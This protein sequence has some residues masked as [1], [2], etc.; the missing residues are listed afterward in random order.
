MG[1]SFVRTLVVVVA[2]CALAACGTI[3]AEQTGA[4]VTAAAPAP[5]SAHPLDAAMLGKYCFTCHNSK[6]R[7]GGL[8]LDTKDLSHVSGDAEVWEKVLRKLR[9]GAMPPLGMPRPDSQTTVAFVQALEAQLDREA[10]L[11]PRPG[12]T[13]ALHR[14]NRAEYKNAIRDLLAL[15]IDTTTLLPPDAAD[16]QGL[17]NN[18]SLLTVSPALL[19]RYQILGQRVS[20]LAL[21]MPPSGPDIETFKMSKLSTQDGQGEGLPFGSRGGGAIRYNF[22]AD[23]KYVVKL[24]LKRQLYDYIIGLNEPE[25]IDLRIDGESV[26]TFKVGGEDHGLTAP[27]S[28]GGEIFGDPDWEHWVIHA[29][30]NFEVRLDVKAGPHVVDVSFAGRHGLA[31]DP[32]LRAKRTGGNLTRDETLPQAI[33][34]VVISGPYGAT[35]GGADTPSLRKIMLCRPATGAD[36]TPCAK[37]IISALAR[38]AYRRPVADKE[39]EGL[40]AF[41]REGRR[42]GD[43][44]AGLQ[45]ALARILTAPSFLFRVEP[46][47]PNLAPGATYRI[48]DLALASRLSFFLWSSIPDATL[49][50]LAVKG[51]L[52][53][54]AVLDQQVRRMIADPKSKALVDNFVGQ[55]LLLRDIRDAAP[56]QDIFPDFGEDL[57]SYFEQETQLFVY[58][59]IT[60]NQSV[61]D[62]LGARYTFLNERLAKHYGIAGVYGP[63]FRRVDLPAE[64]PRGGLL[65]QGSLLMV[66]S[67]PN[68]TSPVLRGKWVLSSLLGTPP[69]QPPANV[70]GLKGADAHGNPATVRARLEEH[71]KNPVCAGCH[72]SMDPLGFAL[73]NF[74]ATGKW[75]TTDAGAPV[76]ASGVL[77]DGTAF[78]GPIG[79]RDALLARKEQFVGA[80]TEKLLAYALGRHI[81]AADM[82]TVRKI[83]HDA[84]PDDYRWQSILAGIA[85]S[86]PFLMRTAASADTAPAAGSSPA[87]DAIIPISDL[88]RGAQP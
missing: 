24:L 79:L 9:M 16:A 23:G 64:S 83:V 71:R 60:R 67:Y 61:V 17:D 21:A 70:P 56:S 18:A 84:Q 19:E 35:A 63:R 2:A 4:K 68:R 58:D 32:T 8:A 7:A 88:K 75:R 40:M 15:D 11:R 33:D 34:S 5:S 37:L 50:D 10:A 78:T 27:D 46:D 29:D 14:L 6:K 76:D 85:K 3:F 69:P 80:M 45:L 87:R 51:R 52:H 38:Q 55:W 77:P 1:R 36:E 39:V 44:T 13:R 86:G 48:S 41:Y 20:R 49:V 42:D 53:Q 26:K 74:D 31:E 47:P 43:F 82:P 54:P 12:R 66:T 57:P 25:Q 65:G 81:D 72:A 59:Q 22:P 30:D 62:L 28:Y 73:E